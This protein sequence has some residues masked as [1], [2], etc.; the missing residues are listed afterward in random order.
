MTP[1]LHHVFILVLLSDCLWADY[2]WM[3]NEWVWVEADAPDG[4]GANLG[5]NLADDEDLFDFDKSSNNGGG[6]GDDLTRFNGGRDGVSDNIDFL[7]RGN[8]PFGGIT[9]DEDFAVD[10]SGGS[11][12]DSDRL[13]PDDPFGRDGHDGSGANSDFDDVG[14]NHYHT[15]HQTSGPSSSYPKQIDVDSSSSYD[16]S[17][18]TSFGGGRHP[19]TNEDD[20]EYYNYSDEVYDNVISPDDEFGGGEEDKDVISIDDSG[21]GRGSSSS[22]LQPVG[23]PY[24][25][26]STAR[27]ARP[28][29]TIPSF[30]TTRRPTTTT[31]APPPVSAGKP[32]RKEPAPPNVIDRPTNRP[33]SFFAQP[34]ILAAVIGGAVVGLLCAILLVMFIV[35]RMRKKDEGSYILDEP[36]RVQH[37]KRGKGEIY[38]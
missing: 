32:G 13:E 3:N 34:G 12:D 17:D 37:A 22:G 5:S 4:S 26:T 29:T 25:T 36:K 14:G 2:K 1:P 7:D 23:Y 35:Y 30:F 28:T 6:G 11:L 18:I 20:D 10:G 16:T 38:A 8:V 33:V 19:T 27:P 21:V 31:P 9:D 15:P 24:T